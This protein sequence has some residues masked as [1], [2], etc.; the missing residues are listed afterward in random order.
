MRA[1]LPWLRELFVAERAAAGSRDLVA[2]ARDG[3]AVVRTVT[4]AVVDALATAVTP[5][6]VVGVA[7]DPTVGV[8]LRDVVGRVGARGFVLVLDHVADPG[9]AGTAIRSADAAGAAGVALTVGSVDPGN[10]KAVRASAGSLF[11]LP[12]ATGVEP[13]AVRDL[14]AD[15]WTVVGLDGRGPTPLHEVDL[16]GRVALVAGGEAHGLSDAVQPACSLV[17]HLPMHAAPRPGYPGRAE[18]LNLAAAV[19]V[20][21]YEVARAQRAG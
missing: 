5:Q 11:H 20:A 6:G 12:V 13:A 4:D 21:A 2:A 17:A 9:N 14:R 7:A 15:G 10:P 16:A 8:H 19:A 18:S 1:A 3:G